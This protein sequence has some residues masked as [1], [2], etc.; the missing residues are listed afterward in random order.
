MG[1]F[2]FFFPKMD[3]HHGSRVGPGELCAFAIQTIEYFLG[4]IF[5]FHICS[6]GKNNY[7]FIAADSINGKTCVFEY[8]ADPMKDGV[9]LF[10][11]M[12]LVKLQEIIQID[13]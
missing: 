1:N 10:M 8:N 13:Q 3:E 9:P 11:T 5:L 4:N 2:K 7:N 12:F 6:L